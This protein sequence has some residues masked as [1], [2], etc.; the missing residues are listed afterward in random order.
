MNFSLS[1]RGKKNVWD[2]AVAE[3][4]L[5][6]FVTFSYSFRCQTK[7][8]IHSIAW[9]RPTLVKSVWCMRYVRVYVYASLANGCRYSLRLSK[10]GKESRGKSRLIFASVSFF[11]TFLPKRLV[12]QLF[13]A[14]FSHGNRNFQVFRVGCRYCFLSINNKR[15]PQSERAL[16]ISMNSLAVNQDENKV[17]WRL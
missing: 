11:C 7:V 17:C 1:T 4:E 9:V 6:V 16:R 2:S 5:C 15:Q 8:R 14:L 12:L 10:I 13:R 3:N